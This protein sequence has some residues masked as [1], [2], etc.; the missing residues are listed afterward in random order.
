M[1]NLPTTIDISGVE[2]R[3]RDNGDF[4]NILNAFVVL[5]DEEL[6]KQEK[7]LTA[8]VIFYDVDSVEDVLE[9]PDVEEAA[10]KM[11]EFFNA[12]RKEHSGPDRKL[13]DWAEDSAMI[14]SAV[15]N[16]ANKEIRAEKYLHWWTFIS[17]YMAVGESTLATVVSIRD[18]ILRGKSLEKWERQFKSENPQYFEWNH[19]TADEIE[20]EQWLKDVWNKE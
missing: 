18:K 16:V 3:L 7:I 10:H 6:D 14:V 13:I 17:Y 5:N 15:N 1:Y 4:R 19:K 8:L 2:Y 20:A 11:F 12:G 9:M